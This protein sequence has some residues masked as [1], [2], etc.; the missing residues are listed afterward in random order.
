ME[1]NKR[2]IKGTARSVQNLLFL[3]VHSS[4]NMAYLHDRKSNGIIK[5]TPISIYIHSFSKTIC[6]HDRENNNKIKGSK[7][8]IKICHF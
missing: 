6:L 1:K 7:T 2:V 5:G 3:Q 4:S 8:F